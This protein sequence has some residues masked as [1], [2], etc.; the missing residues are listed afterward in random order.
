MG[1]FDRLNQSISVYM[2]FQRSQKWWQPNFCFCIHLSVN[3][4][5]QINYYQVSSAGESKIDLRIFKR[6]IVNAYY[7]GYKSFYNSTNSFPVLKSK[8]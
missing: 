1:G 8:L 6:N 5:D 3:T 2:I 7:R 4:A